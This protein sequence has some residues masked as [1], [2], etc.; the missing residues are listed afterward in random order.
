MEF[1][2][3]EPEAPVT[4]ANTLTEVVSFGPA[5]RANGSATEE[6]TSD[7]D[8]PPKTPP[9]NLAEAATVEDLRARLD[10]SNHG[11]YSMADQ[12]QRQQLI[13][14]LL[15]AGQAHQN[16]LM[17]TQLHATAAS[18]AEGSRE[19]NSAAAT[20]GCSCGCCRR[21]ERH[22]ACCTWSTGCTG[23]CCS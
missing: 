14:D 15:L 7:D 12:L 1:P 18:G 21:W 6:A 10:A 19:R 23:N 9:T 5:A 4:T 13:I 3:G 16:E 8:D 11:Q 22:P 20:Q 2:F 17:L